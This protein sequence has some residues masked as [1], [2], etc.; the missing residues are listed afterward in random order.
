MDICRLWITATTLITRIW[1]PKHLPIPVYWTNSTVLS[2]TEMAD[3]KM[4]Q[5]ILADSQYCSNTLPFKEGIR[6]LKKQL[7]GSQTEG[8]TE[9]AMIT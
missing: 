6:Q 7:Q 5:Q 3:N 4:M 2:S 8:T 9:E 1:Q